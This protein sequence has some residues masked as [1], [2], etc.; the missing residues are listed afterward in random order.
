MNKRLLILVVAVSSLLA[1][2]GS[3]AASTNVQSP[4]VATAGNSL[5]VEGKLQ[6]VQSVEF[7]FGM[8]GEVAAVLVIDGDAV[9]AGDVIARLNSDTLQAAVA[10][11]EA[12]LVLAKAN[13]SSLPQ[14]IAD[15]Q[16]AVRSAQA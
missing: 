4:S 14:Q 1:A 13:Q 11:A 16:A 15:A 6:P 5:N 9:K 2:C 7:S 8:S 3:S 12:A 10:Q